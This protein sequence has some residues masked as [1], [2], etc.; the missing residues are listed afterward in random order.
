[1]TQITSGLPL[2][3]IITALCLLTTGCWLCIFSIKRKR[4]GDQPHCRKCDYQLTGIATEQTH[5]PECGKSLISPKAI[6][7][8]KRSLHKPLLFTGLFLILFAC[9]MSAKSAYTFYKTHGWIKLKPTAW[10]IADAVTEFNNATAVNAQPICKAINTDELLGRLELLQLND[11]QLTLTAEHAV[12]LQSQFAT[13]QVNREW[14]RILDELIGQR[15]LPPSL[16]KQ[17]ITQNYAVSLRVKPVIRR[18]RYTSCSVIQRMQQISDQLQFNIK[19][20]HKAV[21]INE[22]I[23]FDMTGKSNSFQSSTHSNSTTGISLYTNKKPFTDIPNGPATLSFTHQLTVRIDKPTG[24][25]PFDITFNTAKPIKLIDKD[26]FADNFIT[27]DRYEKTLDKAWINTRVET[28]EWFTKVWLDMESLPLS[29]AMDVILI[30]DKKQHIIGNVIIEN[31]G[32]HK[33][34][35]I[36]SRKHFNLPQQV[37]V[38][39]K[40]SQN[41]ADWVKTISDYWGKPMQRDRITINAPYTVPMNW[42]QSVMDEMREKITIQLDQPASENQMSLCYNFRELLVDIA[43]IPYYRINGKWQRDKHYYTHGFETKA[44]PDSS[45]SW[46][47]STE[48]QPGQKTISIRLEPDID[49][50]GTSYINIT[51]PWGYAIEFLDLPIPQ[52]DDDAQKRHTGKVIAPGTNLE[53]EPT[54]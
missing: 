51:A 18:T 2:A 21:C 16:L 12:K 20:N 28:T 45:H 25:E 52:N 17:Y 43:Y 30:D 23:A 34:Y 53:N 49:W 15:A 19:T 41:A 31:I 38:L 9:Q 3:Q 26:A 48:I 54:N 46:N 42:D 7:H 47:T 24:Y 8:G 22:Q 11:N 13:W 27:D 40:P 32:E 39:L 4:T 36:R 44:R 1:M 5:C 50:Q 37:S 10:V 6:V 29:L 35:L 14:N 33:W